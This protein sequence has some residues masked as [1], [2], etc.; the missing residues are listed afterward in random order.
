MMAGNKVLSEHLME[1][2]AEDIASDFRKELIKRG[3]Y[4]DYHH[5]YSRQLELI[6]Y[7]FE[8]GFQDG[9]VKK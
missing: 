7:S 3:E 6:A 2:D 1:T 5:F 8:L 4:P 9:Q